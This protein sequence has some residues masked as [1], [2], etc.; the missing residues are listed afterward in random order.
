[1][2]MH[3]CYQ[4]YFFITN[5]IQAIRK[6]YIYIYILYAKSHL[7]YTYTVWNLG[8]DS[9]TFKGL[10]IK[11]QKTNKFFTRKLI[12]KCGIPYQ[13]YKETLIYLNLNSHKLEQLDVILVWYINYLMY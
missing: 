3:K 11:Q 8:L 9:M 10:N 13:P 5:N 2:C 12:E 7:E 1:M 4:S 6:S